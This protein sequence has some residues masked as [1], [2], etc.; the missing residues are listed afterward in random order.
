MCGAGAKGLL[1]LMGI[2]CSIAY[3]IKNRQCRLCGGATEIL[4][5]HLVIV[6]RRSNMPAAC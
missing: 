3:A 5:Y 1:R 6:P 2:Y 4:Y